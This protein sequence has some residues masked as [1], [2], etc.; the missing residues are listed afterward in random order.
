MNKWLIMFA[1]IGT[2]F[3]ALISIIAII[4]VFHMIFGKR[5]ESKKKKPVQNSIAE[6]G[7]TKSATAPV[8]L[9]PAK[10]SAQAQG[11]GELVAVIAA[12]ICAAS[13]ASPSSFRIASIQAAGSGEKES[14]FN[15]PVWGRIER[16]YR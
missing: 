9:A 4:Q 12:A 8:S 2:V 10:P 1:G 5:P 13:G 15:T 7:A 11:D 14:G 6:A 16:F 3:V